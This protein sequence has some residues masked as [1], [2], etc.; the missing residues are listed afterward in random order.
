MAKKRGK[1]LADLPDC[2]FVGISFDKHGGAVLLEYYSG[3]VEF[4]FL[5][6]GVDVLFLFLKNGFFVNIGPILLNVVIG[7]Y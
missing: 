7:N 1:I 4:L 2:E 3:L 5:A 6:V